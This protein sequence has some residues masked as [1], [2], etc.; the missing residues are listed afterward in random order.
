MPTYIITGMGR[1]GTSFL[2]KALINSG[3]N[4]GIRMYGSTN[5]NIDFVNINKEIYDQFNGWG[6]QQLPPDPDKVAKLDFS[7]KS[8]IDANKEEMWGVKEPRFTSTFPLLLP[9]IYEVDDDPFI[10]VAL[11]KP[12]YI[13]KS[14]QRKTGCSYKHG[15]RVAKAYHENIKKLID[16]L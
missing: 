3:V 13:A 15:T 12:K 10:Y 11:R 9:E 14:L 5:E 8:A 4:M 16:F 2:S 1:S 7:F 6:L